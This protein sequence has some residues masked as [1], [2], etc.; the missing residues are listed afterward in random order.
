MATRTQFSLSESERRHRRFSEGFKREKVREIELGLMTAAEL[1]RA[2]D[3]SFTSIYRWLANFGSMKQKKERLIV[4][5]QSDSIQ[6][7]EMKK[8]IA[9]LERI[10]GQKQLLID[11]QQKVIDLAEEEYG[12]D[13]KKKLSGEQLNTSGK[14]EK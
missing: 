10:V 12:V 11:F 1:N 6:L 9:E 14:T 3:V 13:I 4:E 2:Y 7:I 5:S 8:R